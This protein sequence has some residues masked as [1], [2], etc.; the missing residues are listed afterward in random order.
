MK[1]TE[2]KLRTCDCT[3]CGRCV[4]ACRRGVLLLDDDGSRRLVRVA[5]A[6]R[7]AGCRACE[8]S[9]PRG[10][11]AVGEVG[12][13]GFARN[14]FVQGLLPLIFA[15][16]LALPWSLEPEAWQHVDYWKIFGLFVL[17]HVLCCH[18]RLP[19]KLKKQSE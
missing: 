4:E 15:L 17:F 6:S 7:C 9:C 13:S 16:V 8:R 18:L 1:N 11:I 5:D 19:K 14:R 2:I 10:A 3:G 12:R